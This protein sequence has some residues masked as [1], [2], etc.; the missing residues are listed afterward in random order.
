[1]FALASL[2]EFRRYYINYDGMMIYTVLVAAVTFKS[3]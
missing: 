3:I 1:M 2:L